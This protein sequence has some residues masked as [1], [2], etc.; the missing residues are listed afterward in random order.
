MLFRSAMARAI[1][2]TAYA[3]RAWIY[4]EWVESNSNWADGISRDG[5][6][7][8]WYQCHHFAPSSFLLPAP[9][10]T[11]PFPAVVSVVECL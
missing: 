2:A 10:L 6:R 4:F 8:T 9:L 3:L 5:L 7:D 1:H 11:L